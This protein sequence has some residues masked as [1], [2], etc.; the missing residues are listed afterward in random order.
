MYWIIGWLIMSALAVGVE[1]LTKRLVA[2]WF[3]I[4]GA[5]A[6]ILA[7]AGVIWYIQLVVFFALLIVLLAIV[8]NLVKKYFV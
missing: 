7:I 6:M 1:I 5:I 8:R 3:S 2:V 4:G